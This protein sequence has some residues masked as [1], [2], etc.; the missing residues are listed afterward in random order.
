M[1]VKACQITIIL[2]IFAKEAQKN[3][4]EITSCK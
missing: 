3:T 1:L 4:S 2:R